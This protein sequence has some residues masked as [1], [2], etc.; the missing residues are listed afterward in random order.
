MDRKPTGPLCVSVEGP[1]EAL[2]VY[3]LNGFNL[4]LPRMIPLPI[5]P[6]WSKDIVANVQ[7]FVVDYRWR[8]LDDVDC[9]RTLNIMK[10]VSYRL[11]V[12][13]FCP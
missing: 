11:A 1:W 13:E 4:P 6:L 3:S 12:T 7:H 9:F 5:C 8:S 2:I 10:H